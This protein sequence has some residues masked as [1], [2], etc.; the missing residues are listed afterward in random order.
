MQIRSPQTLNLTIPEVP[1]TFPPL[2]PGLRCSG[3]E[4]LGSLGEEEKGR[5]GD[6]AG[7]G[8]VP[9]FQEE[10]S[11]DPETYW[12]HARRGRGAWGKEGEE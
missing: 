4:G 5:E 3:D 1:S 12:E 7:R 2:A 8:R 6:E 11:R 10:S 9:L